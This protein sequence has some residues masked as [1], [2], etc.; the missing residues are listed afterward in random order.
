MDVKGLIE[1]SFKIWFWSIPVESLLNN[2]EII[3]AVLENMGIAYSWWD[4]SLLLTMM[5]HIFKDKIL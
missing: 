3:K 2:N 4:F 5:S 1:H